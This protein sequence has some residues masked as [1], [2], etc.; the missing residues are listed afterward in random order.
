MKF[1]KDGLSIDE[2]RISVLVLAFAFTLGFALYQVIT[3]GD[4]SD[5]LLILLGYEIAAVTG[6]N[7][8]DSIMLNKRKKLSPVTINQSDNSNMNLP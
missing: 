8:A 7:V 2:T 1:L 3:T 4:V 5:N 6:V